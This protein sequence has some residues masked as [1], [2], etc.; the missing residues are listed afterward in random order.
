MIAAVPDWITRAVEDRFDDWARSGGVDDPETRSDVAKLAHDAGERA[1]AAVAEPLRTMLSA[2]IDE[3][4]TTPLAL[5]RPL[6]AFA[7]AV[8]GDAGVPPVVR[9]EFATRKFPDDDYGL[10]PGSLAALGEQVGDM[11][12]TWGAAKAMAHRRRHER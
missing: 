3:Q 11:A 1:A 12:L 10:T 6:V 9:D 7:T 4:R 5:V 2:D 8:L